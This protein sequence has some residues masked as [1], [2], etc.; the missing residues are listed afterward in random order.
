MDATTN[1]ELSCNFTAVDRPPIGTR[2]IRAKGLVNLSVFA[3]GLSFEPQCADRLNVQIPAATF[4][5]K[6]SY[7]EG[8]MIGIIYL[9]D[10]GFCHVEYRVIGFDS[11]YVVDGFLDDSFLSNL[12]E[13]VL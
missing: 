13:G 7:K 2:P 6:V 1:T 11:M 8:E 12:S 5:R 3:C 4:D 10:N 9:S